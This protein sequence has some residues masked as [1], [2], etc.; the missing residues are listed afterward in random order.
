MSY[1]LSPELKKDL[2]SFIL[3]LNTFNN[4]YDNINSISLLNEKSLN[5]LLELRIKLSQFESYLNLFLNNTENEK[6]KLIE[7]KNSKRFNEGSVPKKNELAPILKKDLI[8]LNEEIIKILNYFQYQKSNS[9]NIKEEIL[10]RL[11]EIQNFISDNNSNLNRN[12]Y[13]K[14][15]S[16]ISNSHLKN[17][18]P[19]ISKGLKNTEGINCFISSSLQMLFSCEEYRNSILDISEN[20]VLSFN[21]NINKVAPLLSIKNIFQYLNSNSNLNRDFDYRYYF[22]ILYR[23]LNIPRYETNDPDEFLNC[24]FQNNKFNRDMFSFKI[25]KNLYKINSAGDFSKIRSIGNRNNNNDYILKVKIPNETKNNNTDLQKLVNFY[26]HL[27]ELQIPTEGNRLTHQKLSIN[28]NENNRYLIINL[29][30]TMINGKNTVVSKKKI[31]INKD[32]DIDN[33][34]FKIEGVICYL[35]GHYI[36]IS[37]CNGEIYTVYDDSKVIIINNNNKDY[38]TKLINN[39]A[40]LILYSRL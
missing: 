29:S 7:L 18:C 40:Y 24:F 35:P 12:I 3:F 10:L 31:I 16:T 21:K 28:F 17:N 25:I 4:K 22:I 26:S 36:Y 39:G 32:L 34:Y 9:K 37:M 30:R 5:F 27:E 8:K 11:L 14:Q 15:N 19:K 33:V 38:Y 6:L 13:L 20:T 1:N 23:I 2:K